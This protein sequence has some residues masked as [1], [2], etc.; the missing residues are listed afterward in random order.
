MAAEQ[1]LKLLDSYWFETTILTNKSPLPSQSM[2][3]SISQGTNSLLRRISTLKIWSFSDQNLSS[4]ASFSSDYSPSPNSAPSSPKLRTIL[5]G[6]E[7]AELSVE[8][9]TKIHENEEKPV[10]KRVSQVHR[11]RRRRR[12]TRGKISRSLSELEFKELK[13]FMDLGFVFSEEDKDSKLVTLIP[14]LQRLGSKSGDCE[15]EEEKNDLS[16]IS[17]P[18]LSEAWA[19][20]HQRKVGDSLLNWKV[21]D[22]GDEIEMKDNLRFWAHTVASIVR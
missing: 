22:L 17:R 5:S 2:P 10:K 20:L 11:R 13:G 14:G 16:V 18:Y 9:F 6:K 3:E 1:V 8:N 19:V 12:P 15:E 21:P 7:V 4:T